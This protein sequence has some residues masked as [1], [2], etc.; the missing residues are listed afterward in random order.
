MNRIKFVVTDS[1]NIP[2]RGD[3]FFMIAGAVQVARTKDQDSF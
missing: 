1:R 2:K 3:I